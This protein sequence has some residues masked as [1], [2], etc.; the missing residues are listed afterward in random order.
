M[1]RPVRTALAG[2]GGRP[3]YGSPTSSSTSSS[4]S[5][6]VTFGDI[7]PSPSTRA[8]LSPQ[9]GVV[10]KGDM[11]IIAICKHLN[12]MSGSKGGFILRELDDNTLFCKTSVQDWLRMDVSKE[13]NKLLSLGEDSQADGHSP[14]DWVLGGTPPD[15][16]VDGGSS[17]RRTAP[18]KRGRRPGGGTS[19]T[20][21]RTKK[22]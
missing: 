5:P 15:S 9:E 22:W 11:A 3:P 16:S 6:P 4:A 8:I 17:S 7:G 2:G 1:S 21:K 14:D 20:S 12:G 13:L 10:V 18:K 19:V